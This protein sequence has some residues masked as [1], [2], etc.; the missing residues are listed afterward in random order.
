MKSNYAAIIAQNLFS[1]ATMDPSER[2]A[3]MAAAYQDQS[4]SFQA[5]GRKCTIS[6]Q[7][8]LLG[9]EEQ[10]GPPGIILSLYAL[11][12]TSAPCQLEPLQAFKAFPNSAPYV[13]AFAS[14]TEQ[15]LVPAVDRIIERHQDVAGAMAGQPAPAELGGDDAMVVFPLPKIA[16][17]YIFY[18]A[19]EDFP[20]SATCLFSNN[21]REHMPLDGL[22]DVGEYPSR[23]M[24]EMVKA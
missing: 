22:A 13:G 5:F 23:A 10:W 2:C 20:A 11:N 15:I 1:L 19:D 6:P 16:L 18:R 3:A 24:L 4:Y 17:C 7:T 12:A 21:A 14:H 8:V 9:D